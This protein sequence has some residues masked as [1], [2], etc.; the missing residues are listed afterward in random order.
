MVED[1]VGRWQAAGRHPT[2]I[3]WADRELDPAWELPPRVDSNRSPR[4]ALAEAWAAPAFRRK[5]RVVFLQVAWMAPTGF[6]ADRMG[7][8]WC[9]SSLEAAS[10][11]GP[12]AATPIATSDSLARSQPI[13]LLAI[14]TPNR[15]RRFDPH[16]ARGTQRRCDRLGIE[17]FC[18]ATASSQEKSRRTDSAPAGFEGGGSGWRPTASREL[19]PF[20][21]ICLRRSQ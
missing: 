2:R 13:P 10:R 21:P 19:E 3:P 17:R 14:E 16:S 9:W 6:A 20:R 7:W 12:A 18:I 8:G 4:P 11:R 15:T 5:E 1:P